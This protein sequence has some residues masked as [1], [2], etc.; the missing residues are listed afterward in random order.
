MWPYVVGA[1]GSDACGAAGRGGGLEE[2]NLESR[3]CSTIAHAPDPSSELAALGIAIDER[4]TMSRCRQ[5]LTHLPLPSP[6]VSL[7]PR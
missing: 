7:C 6:A 2:Q 4:S 1:T 3:C 5:S